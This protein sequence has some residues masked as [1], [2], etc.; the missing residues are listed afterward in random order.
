MKDAESREVQY[1]FRRQHSLVR[2]S[3]LRL[4]GVSA[5]VEQAKVDKGEWQRTGR[6]IRLAGAPAT[7][8]QRL[9]A[10]C[11]EAGPTAV[12][13]HQSAAWLWGLASCPDRPA[14]IIGRNSA[15]RLRGVEVH[16]PMVLPERI[17]VLRDIPCTSPL[18]TLRDLAGVCPPD[19]LDAAIDVALAR[20]LVSV[21]AVE[22]EIL[23]SAR[24]GRTGV[25]RLRQALARRGMSGAPH[26]SVLE[27]RVLRLLRRIGIEPLAVE[28]KM[29]S[30][31]RYRVDT[32]LDP[33]VA[34]EVDGYTYH[35]APE[36]KAEDERRRGRLRLGGTFVLV[37]D[38]TEV[39]RDTRRIAAEC[40][41]AIAKYGSA[42][43]RSPR[44][45]S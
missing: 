16:R 13:S 26:P 4:L 44:R 9:M 7:P 28:V 38:W 34:L 39:L 36:L 35:A 24:H 27:S 11:L 25:G 40:H 8:Y 5:K 23:R 6:V 42:G 12:A 45:V 17:S 41:E 30:D 10:A 1:R 3:E 43:K 2:R 18:R 22:A 29:G 14:I 31:G 32:L 37:Y 15:T 19:V 21:A 33:G 20:R